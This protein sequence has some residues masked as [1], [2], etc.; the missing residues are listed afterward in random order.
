MVEK[1]GLYWHFMDPDIFVFWILSALIYRITNY[2]LINL[3][4]LLMGHDYT[5]AKIALKTIII[6]AVDSGR[7]YDCADGQGYIVE[8]YHAPKIL[9]NPLMISMSI[10]SHPIVF[11]FMH[12]KY[13]AK[14]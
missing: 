7:S 10:Q 11:E 5:G 12:M 14:G 3:K 2:K 1:I 13:E 6:L 4:S 8:G 9:M